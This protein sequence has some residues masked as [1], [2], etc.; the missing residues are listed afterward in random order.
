[1]SSFTFPLEFDDFLGL[2]PISG[3]SMT[4]PD[5]SETSQTGGGEI[6]T[7]EVGPRLWRGKVDVAPRT[8]AEAIQI[9]T[10]LDTASGVGRGF[11]ATDITH[12]GPTSDPDGAALDGYSPV[13]DSLHGDNLRLRISGLPAGYVLTRGDCLAFEY[14]SSPTR[15]ALHRI[16]SLSKAADET[17]LTTWIEV[18]NSIRTGVAVA[19]PVTLFRPSCKALIVPGSISAGT[20]RRNRT[21]GVSFNFMQT[22]R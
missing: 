6:L 1:M 10:L 15:F 16:A 19:A 4:C 12:Q 8:R 11:M 7:N 2:L 17:G 22:L 14:G 21:D 20:T 5:Q 3:F 9:E 18:S 13:I